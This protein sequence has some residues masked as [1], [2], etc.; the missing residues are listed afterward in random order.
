M[1]SSYYVP[2]VDIFFL[3]PMIN[4]ETNFLTNQIVF[5]KLHSESLKLVLICQK[6]W[7]HPAGSQEGLKLGRVEV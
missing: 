1:I 6:I 4:S 2:A 5:D 7:M 3:D